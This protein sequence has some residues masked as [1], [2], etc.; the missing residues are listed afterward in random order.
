[1]CLRL[2]ETNLVPDLRYEGFRFLVG[3]TFPIRSFCNW[4]TPTLAQARRSARSITFMHDDGLRVRPFQ[5]R[6]GRLVIHRVPARVDEGRAV[7]PQI[8]PP[9]DVPAVDAL[10]RGAVRRW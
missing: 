8:R 9:E 5:D 4:S 2:A 6:H 7:P 1:M 10:H 3:A